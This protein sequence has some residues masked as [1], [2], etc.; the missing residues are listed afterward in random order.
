M[1]AIFE[2]VR[3]VENINK[4]MAKM[5]IFLSKPLGFLM[6]NQAIGSTDK[7]LNDLKILVTIST[8]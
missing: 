4:K 3:T 1:R 8:D 5:V 2:P 6:I 7:K